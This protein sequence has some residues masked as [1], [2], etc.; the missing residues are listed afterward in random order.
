MACNAV[1][2]V[3][4]L[5]CLGLISMVTKSRVI[6]VLILSLCTARAAGAQQPAAPQP[7]SSAAGRVVVTISL[8]GLRIPAVRVELR[9]ADGNVV[10]GQ[11]T[12]DAVGQVDVPR[13]VRRTLCRAGRP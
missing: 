13:R 6:G 10:V 1:R 7:Q 12:S 9:D 4:L 3:R 8:E 11:T 2:S 5:V